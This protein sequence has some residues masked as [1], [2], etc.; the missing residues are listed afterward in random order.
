MA[1]LLAAWPYT[2]LWATFLFR[3][4]G[5]LKAAAQPGGLYAAA[6]A[7]GL[8]G[9]GRLMTGG[10]V[11][12]GLVESGAKVFIFTQLVRYSGLGWFE[13]GQFDFSLWTLLIG[14]ALITAARVMRLGATMREE[15]DVT[16]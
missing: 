13:P 4:R 15:L 8:Q 3:L 12:A 1:G 11:A 10:A 5:V 14:L 6:T 7:T 9:L 16:V 2:L